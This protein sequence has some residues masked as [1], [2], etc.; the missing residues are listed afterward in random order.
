LSKEQL[1]ILFDFISTKDQSQR[2][3][4]W[5]IVKQKIHESNESFKRTLQKLKLT[6]I[7]FEEKKDQEENNNSLENLENQ[8]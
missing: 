5:D 2:E 7:Q 1:I 6:Q 3:K 4:K 8:F